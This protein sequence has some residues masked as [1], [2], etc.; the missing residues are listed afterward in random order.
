MSHVILFFNTEI[1]QAKSTALRAASGRKT[2]ALELGLAYLGVASV[3]TTEVSI[4]D[5][6]TVTP[7]ERLF[8]NLKAK[9]IL[10]AQ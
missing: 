4:F 10:A 5:S 7:Y 1:S 9:V 3:D 8:E 6:E 2:W